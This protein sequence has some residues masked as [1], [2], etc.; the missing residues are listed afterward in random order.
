MKKLLLLTI[1]AALL[2]AVTSC[3][4][5]MDAPVVSDTMFMVYVEGGTFDMGWADVAEPVH[6]VKLDSYSI[7]KYPVTQLQWESVMVA[8]PSHFRGES[9]RP[10]EMVSWNAIVGTSGQYMDIKGIRYYENGFIYR[11]NSMTG[12]QYRLPTEA[13]W[14]YAARGGKHNS[15]FTYSGSNT[16]V[17]VAWTWENSAIGGTRQTHPVGKKAANALGIFDMSGNVWELCA[18]KYAAYTAGAKTDPLVTVGAGAVAHGGCYNLNATY[19][20]V[21]YRYS[22]SIV[23]GH[24]TAGFR[25][26]L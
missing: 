23:E 9:D 12:K 16:L 26:A 4:D 8:N 14:E 20:H 11:L 13:E 6:P 24:P 25:L 19:A 10:V 18:D 5:K 22:F 15:P 1:A 21:S 2:T 7:G 3:N 17:N